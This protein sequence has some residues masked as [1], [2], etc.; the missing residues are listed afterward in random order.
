MALVRMALARW[1]ACQ[2]S[3]SDCSRG[4]GK[5]AERRVG[6]EVRDDERLLLQLLLRLLEREGDRIE[7][8]VVA[9]I[10]SDGDCGGIDEED[11][12]ED[13]DDEAGCC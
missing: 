8:P 13:E 1:F 2:I 10:S 4:G 9:A 7:K 6:D 11:E 5:T 12:D 3:L